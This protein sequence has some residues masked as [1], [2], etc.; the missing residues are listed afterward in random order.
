MKACSHRNLIFVQEMGIGGTSQW[1]ICSLNPSTT[2]GLYFEVVNQVN[3][4]ANT[5]KLQLMGSFQADESGAFLLN[6]WMCGKT[7][8][9][10][11]SIWLF[12]SQ[13]LKI[14]L[15]VPILYFRSAAQRTDPP[16][17]PR[18]DPVCYPVSAFQHAEEDS[19]HHHRQEVRLQNSAWS[20]FCLKLDGSYKRTLRIFNRHKLGV[21]KKWQ[22]ILASPERMF[23]LLLGLTTP[24]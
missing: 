14:H 1:K 23:T 19:G 7:E 9:S 6:G 13:P 20:Y 8:N 16:G 5:H 2:L 15:N 17:R 22:S 18:G 11:N 12:E 10:V 4:K 21:L 3:D 24:A